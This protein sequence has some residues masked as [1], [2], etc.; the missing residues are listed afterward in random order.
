MHKCMVN[1]IVH[2]KH[3]EQI[4]V[5]GWITVLLFLHAIRMQSAIG[6]YTEYIKIYV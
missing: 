2:G 6:T 4:P 1:K 5:I 3:F